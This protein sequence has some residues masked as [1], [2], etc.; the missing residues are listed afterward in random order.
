MS[1]LLLGLVLLVAQKTTDDHAGH[2][3]DQPLGRAL[4]GLVV[5][6]GLLRAL[7]LLLRGAQLTR[8]QVD[9]VTDL[10]RALGEP[11]G[12]A[13]HQR[14]PVV[15]LAGRLTRPGR[16]QLVEVAFEILGQA[17]EGVPQRTPLARQALHLPRVAGVHRV[18]ELAVADVLVALRVVRHC[19][20]P[21]R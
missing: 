19:R 3:G 2:A 21:A 6:V 17:V 16:C 14:Q 7:R 11:G 10:G 5:I 18:V 9:R 12:I 1:L 20:P 13:H 8:H 4:D 15:E